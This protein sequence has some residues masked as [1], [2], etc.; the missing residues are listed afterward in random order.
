MDGTWD[1]PS[2]QTVSPTNEDEN[3]D[4]WIQIAGYFEGVGTNTFKYLGG[5]FGLG[6]SNQILKAYAFISEN[7]RNTHDEIWIVGHSRG[8]YAARSLAGMIYNVGLL[9]CKLIPQRIRAAYRLYSQRKES[10]HPHDSAAV[11]FRKDNNCAEPFIR[12]LGCFDTVGTLGVP[13]L[14]WYLGGS[15]FWTLFHGLHSFHDTK[16][17]PM[18]VSAFHAISIHDQRAWF[19]PTLMQYSA[20]KRDYQELEQVWFPGMHGDIGGE[21]QARLLPN[22]T[23]AWM[24]AK[25][26]ER[27]LVFRNSIDVLCGGG[28]FYYNDSYDSSIIYRLLPRKDR[29]IDPDVFGQF[30]RRAV[31][32]EG[33][34]ETFMTPDQLSLYRSKTLEVFFEYLEKRTTV[35]NSKVP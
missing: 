23:L 14:P 13:R 27:G 28:A 29:I 19:K 24:M 4:R 2:A 10:S 35:Q 6:I 22:H 30:G 18:V 20:R 34:F 16:I 21:S 8:A 1:T 32:K 7:Y 33:A 11:K 31:Y 12:F 26:Q 9:P 3:H 25:A 5:A 17:S 15:I